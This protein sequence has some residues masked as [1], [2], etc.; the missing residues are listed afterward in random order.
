MLRNWQDYKNVFLTLLT[1]GKISDYYW[2]IWFH[3]YHYYESNWWLYYFESIFLKNFN[4]KCDI[5]LCFLES[6]PGGK[7][8]PHP[9]YIFDS[10]RSSEFLDGNKDN[11][12][13]NILK[14]FKVSLNNKNSL[15]VVLKSLAQQNVLIIDIYPTH[16]MTISSRNENREKYFNHFF[17]S[18]TQD[19]LIDISSKIFSVSKTSVN[20]SNTIYCSRELHNSGIVNSKL[21]YLGINNPSFTCF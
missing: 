20:Y 6:C 19:K 21:N 2:S 10:N 11:Y 4:S 17:N 18:Y 16:G 15:E 1:F 12:L 14:A 13:L 3:Q 9:N 5:K 8:F 7:P